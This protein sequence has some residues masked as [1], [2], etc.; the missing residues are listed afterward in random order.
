[1]GTRFVLGAAGSG[2]TRYLHEAL[3]QHI[4]SDPLQRSAWVIVPKQ[5]TFI[6]E[7]ALACD[8]RLRGLINIRVTAP[9]EIGEMAL[10]ETGASAGARLDALGRKLIL[11]HL[12]HTHSNE[13]EYFGKSATQ[14][15][16]AEEIDRVFI[17]F[18]HA[19]RPLKD[20]NDLIESTR[21]N[22]DTHLQALS[23]KL[24]DL[25]RLYQLY[26]QY[27][28]QYGFDSY[29]RQQ[30][31]LNAIRGCPFIKNSLILIDDFHE[32]TVYERQILTAVV[33]TAPQSLISMLVSPGSPLIQNIHHL[34][35]ETH[36][37]YKS[38]FTYRKL[39][40]SLTQAGVV[41]EPPVILTET[42][43]YMSPVL[44]SLQQG[45][46]NRSL[47]RITQDPVNPSVQRIETDTPEAEVDA[48]AC[49]ILDLL[50]SGYRMRDICILARSIE[51][52]EPFIESSF[53]E[54]G[55]SFF[56]DKRRP[57]VH[58]P[59][60]R[61][62]IALGQIVQAKGSHEGIIELLRAGLTDVRPHEADLL[63]DYIRQHHIPPS[64]WSDNHP[65]TFN[66]PIPADEESVSTPS[67][68]T[69]YE[70]EKV[71]TIQAYVRQNLGILFQPRW[72]NQNATIRDRIKDL[73]DILRNLNFEKHLYRL[74]EEAEKAKDFQ[75]QE[76]HLQIWTRVMET[77]D[78]I[79]QLLGEVEVTAERFSALMQQTLS[80]LDLAITPPTVDQILIGSVDR[81]RAPNPKVVILL[82]MNAG[83]FPKVLSEKP[84]L[85][86]RDRHQLS[87][88]GVEITAS[89]DQILMDE[90]FLGYLSLTRSREKILLLRTVVDSSGNS[91]EASP[92]WK[93][94][95]QLIESVPTKRLG[96]RFEQI[97]TPRQAISLILDWARH[98]PPD[99]STDDMHALYQWVVQTNAD[100]IRKIRDRAWP[101]L[102]YI[103][104]ANLSSENAQRL[105]GRRLESS[106][107]RFE[108]FAACPFQH[109]AR[110]GLRLQA[111][112]EPE[113]TALDLG[114]LYHSVLEK[115]VKRII[116]QRLDFTDAPLSSE[117]IQQIAQEVGEQLRNQIF[118]TNA[119]NRYTLERIQ[120]VVYRLLQAQQYVLS[121][122]SFRPGFVELVFGRRGQWQPLKLN[123]PNGNE[124]VINGKIDRIDIDMTNGRYT[125]I[126]YKLSGKSLSMTEVW[127]GLSL[128]LLTYLLVIQANRAC[129]P[130]ENLRP[131]GAFYLQLRRPLESVKD[132]AKTPSPNNPEF[133]IK[134]KPRGL[135]NGEAATCLDPNLNPGERS[136]LFKIQLKTDGSFSQKGCD[137]VP[138]QQFEQIIDFVRDK[139][140][141]LADQIIAGY[142]K[143]E[144]Y[145]IH[146]E[147][148]CSRCD[149]ARVCRFDRQI[150]RY[151]VL[152]ELGQIEALEQIVQ[153]R[154]P[155][156]Q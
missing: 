129:L 150:N 75:L 50:R 64:Q 68:F 143:V 35:E 39:Y 156:E 119:Q 132:P 9:D 10:I 79:V 37:L 18:E 2:K 90:H 102:Q 24:S 86:D 128:Q 113:L 99:I 34:P 97:A 4:A 80:E 140:G 127:H 48:A 70:L 122:G 155:H 26:Q 53:S 44:A 17:E 19:G 66:R 91:L 87:R 56:T 47:H 106:V 94:L 67:L 33:S 92:Y 114:I 38:E 20:I 142:I 107:S 111:P 60:V 7:Q 59:L 120:H 95:D 71:K 104:D 32:L 15:G 29:Q 112:P 16:L 3:V 5:S 63:D 81:T 133:H 6:T 121:K 131:A 110:Y 54:H 103:N 28:Q 136:E 77:I 148:P 83:Q 62:L 14:P 69:K 46:L 147:S 45:L 93:W 125:V 117:Q 124:V 11:T 43:R 76:L 27:L 57:A 118:L 84:L 126:D 134:I 42:P 101:A 58:H 130:H 154:A 72:N 115:F 98:S 49:H 105:F 23:R 25:E 51:E 8:P 78:Q 88:F 149:F 55:L 13:L 123:T 12:L 65:W 138:V 61:S 137:A 40:F 52:Y 144:P 73:M 96:S 41:L 151:K 100:S 139:I 109:F 141:E 116:E 36:L 74:I 31:A 152:P 30:Q 153:R 21:N 146:S 82:G 1:M 145:L 89:S 85:N 108:S 22:P 135:I